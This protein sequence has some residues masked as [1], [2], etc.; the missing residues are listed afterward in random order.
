MH[1]FITGGAGFIGSHIAEYHL[2]KG[3]QV[4]VVDNLSTGSLDNIK[5]CIK[6]NNFQYEIAD[7]LTWGGLTEAAHWADRIYHMAAVVGLF[8]VIENPIEVLATNIAGCERV[9]RAA[10]TNKWLPQIMIASSSSVYGANTKQPHHEDDHLIFKSTKQGL[11]TYAVSKFA[12]ESFCHAYA[13][14]KEVKTTIVRLFN[15]IGPR[16]VGSYGMVVPRFIQQ[17]TSGEPITVHGDGRQTRSFCDVRDTVIMLDLLINNAKSINEVVN[18]GYDR[19]ISINDLALLIKKISHSKSV[20]KHLSYQDV[21]GEPI[22]DIKRRL[23]C[24]KKLRSLISYTNKWSLE[25]TIRD[26][27]QR[28][29]LTGTNLEK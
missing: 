18:V 17:A 15:N 11:W 10:A 2:L 22:D 6:N 3:D 28:C 14:K 8:R 9:L 20:I 24:L 19:E 23:P 27:A 12:D 7:I 1:V 29:S 25:D 21:Y 16:Q 13:S 26:L 5:E 4:Y